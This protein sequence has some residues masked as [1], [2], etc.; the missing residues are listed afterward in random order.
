[1]F[2]EENELSTDYE[3]RCGNCHKFL[4][5]NAKYC[6]F[7]GTKRGEGKFEPYENIIYT[8]YGPPY[9]KSFYCVDCNKSWGTSARFS[10]TR[11]CPFCNKTN[12]CHIGDRVAWYDWGRELKVIEDKKP[13]LTLDEIKKLLSLR[14]DKEMDYLDAQD[15]FISKGYKGIRKAINEGFEEEDKARLE[16]LIFNDVKGELNE[17]AIDCECPICKSSIIARFIDSSLMGHYKGLYFIAKE[18]GGEILFRKTCLVCGT[19]FN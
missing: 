4:V 7:C 13:L 6:Q 11:N 8:V 2:E 15:Y 16:F 3:N 14:L 19:N 1:M 17:T 9:I 18:E 5:E 10:K 12:F